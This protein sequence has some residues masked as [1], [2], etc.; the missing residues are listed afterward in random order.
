MANVFLDAFL[1]VEVVF[2]C[3]CHRGK[4]NHAV[5]VR[6][7]E[8]PTSL[9]LALK[10]GLLESEKKPNGGKQEGAAKFGFVKV[11]IEPAPHIPGCLLA[12][13]NA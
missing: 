9:F 8:L 11:E 3:I 10:F 2:F 4:K 7:V 13:I 1:F 5:H 6:D 12:Q